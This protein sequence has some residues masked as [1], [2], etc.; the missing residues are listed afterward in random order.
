MI[1]LLKNA[2]PVPGGERGFQ[3]LAGAVDAAP[4]ASIARRD[5]HR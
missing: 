3:K 1:K 4:F 2:P 5:T